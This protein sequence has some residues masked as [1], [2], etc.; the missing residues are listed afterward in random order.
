MIKIKGLGIIEQILPK[1]SKFLIREK[2]FKFPCVDGKQIRK[3][4]FKT[5]IIKELK[6]ITKNDYI[7]VEINQKSLQIIWGGV[8]VANPHYLTTK[9]KNDLNLNFF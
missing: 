6:D 8:E 1:E 4:L 3:R 7:G 2:Y 9:V 5:P